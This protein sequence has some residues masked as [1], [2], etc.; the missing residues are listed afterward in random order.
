MGAAQIAVIDDDHGICHAISSLVRSAGYRCATF[1]S[2]EAFLASGRLGDTDCITLDIRMP[3]MDGLDLQLI[4]SQMNCDIP[5][6]YVTATVDSAARERA[7]RQRAVAFLA[8]PF[9]DEDL[10]NAIDDALN[11]S[12]PNGHGTPLLS[13]RR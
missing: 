5:T 7:I 1:G 10:L 9:D 3:G 13:G 2:A 8:K 11:G 12:G 4:L 6:V